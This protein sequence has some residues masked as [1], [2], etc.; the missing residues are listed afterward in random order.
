MSYDYQPPCVLPRFM[1]RY[2]EEIE[3]DLYWRTGVVL[4]SGSLDARA[5]GK[6]DLRERR[7]S[8]EVYGQDRRAYFKMLRGTL[9]NINEDFQKLEPTEWVP[10]PGYEVQIQK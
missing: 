7:I 10:L 5:Q 1:V 6:K 8:I 9:H 3:A 4:R 2:A